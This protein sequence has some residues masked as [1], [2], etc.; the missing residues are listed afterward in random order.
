[1]SSESMTCAGILALGSLLICTPPL[2][3]QAGRPQ[4]SEGNRLYEEGRFQEAHEKYLEGF[5]VAPESGVIS[6]N[7]GNSLYRGE[8]Y[9][10]AGEA[11]QRAIEAGDPALESAA[12]YNLGNALYRQ[13]QLQESLEAFKQSLRLDPGDTDAKH[14]LERVLEEIQSQEE[15]QQQ[16][17]DGGENQDDQE[18]QDEDQDQQDQQQEEQQQDPEQQD[19]EDS[20]QNPDEQNEQ[21]GEA[22]P[23]PEPGQMTPEEA[24]RL[25]EAIEE[26]P[27]DVNRRAA[28]ATGRR[29][30]RPW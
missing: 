22:S 20:Q 2:E 16:Q 18:Q 19:E 26:D 3:A 17:H 4:V 9:V 10:R 6:F 25:L 5:A 14:N 27:E 12:W 13:Q 24:E 7:D 30:R 29:P 28:P 1:V 23:Q 11:Y 21:D 15:E 8:D